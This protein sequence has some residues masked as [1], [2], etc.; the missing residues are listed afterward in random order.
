MSALICFGPVVP[1]V[2]AAA[3]RVG[4]EAD[5]VRGAGL[6]GVA[7]ETGVRA[8]VDAELALVEGRVGAAGRL[9]GGPTAVVVVPASAIV[10]ETVTVTSVL[11]AFEQPAISTVA[12]PTQAAR[13]LSGNRENCREG[14]A[15][16][17]GDGQLNV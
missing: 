4:G 11:V 5:V 8:A 6:L 3:E 10:E 13:R 2:E 1:V 16:G 12:A 7:E 9:E 17:S 14:R 15:A